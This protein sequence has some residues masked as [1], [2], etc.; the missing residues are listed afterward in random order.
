MKNYLDLAGVILVAIN[1][2]GTITLLNKKGYE[3]LG[4]KEGELLGKNWFEICIP[5]KNREELKNVFKALIKGE[6]EPF[7][8]YN[9]SIITKAGDELLIS[10]H[11]ALLYDDDGSIVASLSSGEDITELKE[12]EEK[13]RESQENLR[14]LFN[15]IPIGIHMYHL[16]EDGRLVFIGANPAADEILNVDNMEFVGK[17]IE[18]AFPPLIETD[19]PDRYRELART[20]GSWKWDHVEYEDERI[21]GA[22]QV[23]A[24]QISP[25]YMVATFT[26][27]SER[28]KTE[29]QLK[30]K[31]KMLEKKVEEL[32]K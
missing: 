21:K 11:N 27:I 9:N 5:K 15:S 10:W 30:E 8:F 29:E 3:I 19:I 14:S 31:I 32:T 13:L 1:R 22:Y 6:L 2:E 7:E 26:D 18:E 12:T 24:F 17:S 4:Y 20:E 16:Y 28:L 25:S 23:H